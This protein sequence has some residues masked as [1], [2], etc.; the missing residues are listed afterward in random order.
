MEARRSNL[1][2]RRTGT[3]TNSLAFA[4]HDCHTCASMH[5]ACDRRRPQCGTCLACNR[6]C[7]GFVLDLTWRES[8][9][10][11]SK[12]ATTSKPPPDS[13]FAKAHG[14]FTFVQ[15]RPKRKRK[16]KEGRSAQYQN[17]S[18]QWRLLP[19]S[20]QA[21]VRP[22]NSDIDALNGEVYERSA[23]HD[24]A[25]ANN[26]HDTALLVSSTT[27]NDNS[28]QNAS[29]PS[30]DSCTD[31]AFTNESYGTP[32]DTWL[33]SSTHNDCSSNL[34][35]GR[36]LT[37]FDHVATAPFELDYRPDLHTIPTTLSH[38]S[39]ADKYRGVLELCENLES[40]FYV[41]L[42]ATDDQYFCVIPLSGDCPSNPFRFRM[43][44]IG[45]SPYLLH[46]V[47]AIASQHIAKQNNDS[48]MAAQTRNHWSTA[49]KLFSSALETPEYRSILDTLI[50]LINFE[51]SIS[52]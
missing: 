41:A 4:K 24:L 9:Q 33:I 42:I 3:R 47:M 32:S 46:A 5:E 2:A 31:S 25:A 10:M 19:S 36:N 8:V 49:I 45:E 17:L 30:T 18:H 12:D 13:T 14:N 11:R 7:G 29:S 52:S 27:A 22:K 21:S 38:L 16:V 50:V 39:L 44:R 15:G 51:V 43:N 28:P 34:E 35:D 37:M 40:F 1:V 20:S 26:D 23:V 6:T 48:I